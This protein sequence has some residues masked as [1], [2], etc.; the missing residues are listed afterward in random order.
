VGWIA[1]AHNKS[2]VLVLAILFC[3]NDQSGSSS[4][5]ATVID[6]LRRMN[7]TTRAMT[8]TM[9]RAKTGSRRWLLESLRALWDRSFARRHLPARRASSSANLTRVSS[10]DRCPSGP[11][12]GGATLIANLELEFHV[13]PIRITKLGFSNRKYSPLF[14][15]PWRIAIS[16]SA[17]SSGVAGRPLAPRRPG[18][19]GPVVSR[20]LI[21]T[22]RL[23]FRAIKTK[24][25][26]SLISNRYKMHFSRFKSLGEKPAEKA[27][28]GGQR[29]ELQRQES[30]PREHHRDA[31][32]AQDAGATKE[33][34][35]QKRG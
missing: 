19:E 33:T 4:Q 30:R 16:R 24:Q 29:Y 2:T 20:F 5:S 17:F 9:V 18:P 34:G 32:S 11:L 25:M 7:A 6:E 14:R 13:S 28:A 35:V 22:P 23:E 27:P 10:T 1:R 15:P 8:S 21:V 12:R 3:T 26:P 31:D